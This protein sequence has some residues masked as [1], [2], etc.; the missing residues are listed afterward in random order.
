MRSLLLIL[1][2]AFPAASHE[3]WDLL[4][5]NQF[6]R[7]KVLL[8]RNF[9]VDSKEEGSSAIHLAARAGNLAAVKFLVAQGSDPDDRD[10]QRYTPLMH[11]AFR[12]DLAMTEF[13]V[14]RGAS[15]DAFSESFQTP[16]MIAVVR[17][18]DTVV[19]FLLK[20]N[21]D[22]LFQPPNGGFPRTS[23]A[24]FLSV[25]SRDTASFEMLFSARPD[26][27]LRLSDGQTLL[28]AAAKANSLRLVRRFLSMNADDSARDQEG[29]TALHH[30]CQAGADTGILEQLLLNGADPDAKNA[31]LET[32]LHLAVLSKN[33]ANVRVLLRGKI[34]VDFPDRLGN[35]PMMRALTS[36]EEEIALLLKDKG[37]NPVVSSTYR[38]DPNILV[39]DKSSR[40]VK[41]VIAAGADVN[42]M[43]YPYNHCGEDRYERILTLAA[44]QGWNDVIDQAMAKGANP[45]LTN[46]KHLTA[47]Q[48]A[49]ENHRYGAFQMLLKRGA[50]VDSSL[51]GGYL[52][53]LVAS[54]DS[55]NAIS[56][57]LK[58]GANV[59]D[60]D[61]SGRTP[62]MIAA[63]AKQEM[64]VKVLLKSKA[65]PTLRDGR[66]RTA[67]HDAIE[68]GCFECAKVLLEKGSSV[69]DVYPEGQSLVSLAVARQDTVM[70]KWLLAKGAPAVLAGDVYEKV[71]GEGGSEEI[72]R[73]VVRK[74]S[75]VDLGKALLKAV[76]NDNADLVRFLIEKK[77]DVNARDYDGR[78]PLMIN[79]AYS[80]SREIRELLEE[81]GAKLKLRDKSGVSAEQYCAPNEG[82]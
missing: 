12:G 54:D 4:Q 81:N 82:E 28:M 65:D 18:R 79:C 23:N 78:T 61:R 20:K 45:A 70:A 22:P 77:A 11:A 40:L 32:P 35:T 34:D 29:N 48:C 5:A 55:L 16:L 58:S 30:A 2:V 27:N 59:D 75:G 7:A 73:F 62:L 24:L 53:W 57:L 9:Y 39:P 71:F 15:L 46:G 33:V 26:P 31:S 17:G 68:S 36:G 63:S 21:A 49:M 6:D 43:V 64:N 10:R 8:G 72:V 67:L 56:V 14:G 51:A 13:L 44:S 50:K 69:K 3:L 1:M 38:N 41:L 52:R 19:D 25:G 60:R 80:G 74:M 76:S 47:L 37:A 66:G 42:T